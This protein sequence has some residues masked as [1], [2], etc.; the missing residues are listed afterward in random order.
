MAEIG[1]DERAR[2]ELLALGEPLRLPELVDLVG[3]DAL[4]AVERARARHG[5]GS[6]GPRRCGVAHPLYGE[7]VRGVDARRRARTTC[8]C[9]SRGSWT[10]APIATR[11]D[12]LR[13][14]ALAA[15]RRRADP[16]PGSASRPPGR[17]T[18]AGD[19]ELGARLA[20][21]ARRRRRRRRRRRCCSPAR[22][23]VRKRFEEAE[24]VLAAVEDDLADQ[25][26]AFDYL[27]Q[28]ATVL[29][30]G[31]RTARRHARAAR[32]AGSSWWPDGSWQ[33]RVRAAPAG[34]PLCS[35]HG[36]AR[37]LGPAEEIL[38]DPELEPPARRASAGRPRREPVLHAAAPSRRCALARRLRPSVPLRDAHDELALDVCS[39]VGGEAGEDLR[40][41]RRV[42][43]D[44][45]RRGRP[46]R[47]QRGGG[48]RGADARRA[49]R[50]RRPLRRRGALARRVGRALRAAR[51]V[52]LPRAGARPAGRRRATSRGDARARRGGDR[53]P[54]GRARRP[55][56]CATP[57]GR[58]CVARRG[59]GAARGGRRARPRSG[60]C[61]RPPSRAA[62]MPFYGIHLR[63]EALR[64][65]ASAR[66][67]RRA[68]GRA[69][70]ALRRAPGG[71]V[72]RLTW[73][74]TRPATAPPCCGVADEFAAIGTHRYAAR[75]P[76]TRP[77]CSPT[78]AGRTRR[79]ARRHAA[80]SCTRSARTACPADPR[81]RRRG[82]R[83]HPARG[84]AR[85]LAARG[86]LE[87]RDRRPAGALG[88][89]RR[90]APLPRDAEA[91]RQRSARPLTG[92]AFSRGGR[93]ASRRCG[94]RGAPAR[95]ARSGGRR[96]PRC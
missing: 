61:S 65:G 76:P 40:R 31:L 84:A 50:L 57:S 26:A 55:A 4:A 7:V 64:A 92:G 89:H 3:T 51:P 77:R 39:T 70:R 5:A 56:R 10:R 9:G 78:P 6:R 80:A 12:A 41:V 60:C 19:P 32:R 16:A 79:A 18:L 86:P 2:V 21:L 69:A 42:D 38:A 43:A 25:D 49:R 82:R 24:A 17:R 34:V 96:P 11:D 14:R 52:R 44:D 83:A 74:R 93:R 94:C 46:Q 68:G 66:A 53:A 47:R 85:R 72:R 87:R 27:Q 13:D 95:A 73:A 88:A 28:R 48:D 90:V 71:R 35:L 63:Y 59:L 29:F 23:A 33:R 91:R 30:W 75:A 81:R 67:A 45:D 36:A 58:T 1:A 15:R 54:P 8:G 37:T 22:C 62:G 20:R